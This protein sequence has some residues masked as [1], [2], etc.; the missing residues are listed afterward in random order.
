MLLPLMGL[1]FFCL[2]L[3]PFAIIHALLEAQARSISSL[4]RFY[5][6]SLC[7]PFLVSATFETLE[8]Q[9]IWPDARFG[10]LVLLAPFGGALFDRI[11][12][13]FL[14]STA[15]PRRLLPAIAASALL[16][17]GVFFHFVY[18]ASMDIN[19]VYDEQSLRGIWKGRD[20]ELVLADWTRDGDWG[21]IV[22]GRR[23]RVIR[24]F[25]QLCLAEAMDP[26]EMTILY[27]KLPGR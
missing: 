11:W 20:G 1:I 3:A 15:S 4:L 18:I 5:F 8:L 16:V 21:L 10:F 12:R 23:Y 2:V 17:A 13:Q 27:R 9:N 6:G 25:G 24:S 7:W 14:R 26:D 22:N 19:P